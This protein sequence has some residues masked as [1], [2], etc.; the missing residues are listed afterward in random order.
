MTRLNL[1]TQVAIL[2]LALAL[3][4]PV[5]MA[6]ATWSY[7]LYANGTDVPMETYWTGWN[8][9]RWVDYSPYG[10]WFQK[11]DG[12]V[13]RA[14]WI[15]CGANPAGGYESGGPK[16]SVSNADPAPGVYLKDN[17]SGGYQRFCLAFVSDSGSA[18]TFEGALDW[19]GDFNP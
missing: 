10:I 11:Y 9:Q 6:K 8:T 2:A 19:D 7:W 17:F 16:K 12:P 4:I 3:L 18:D 14:R 15:Y 5:G 13:M 1:K